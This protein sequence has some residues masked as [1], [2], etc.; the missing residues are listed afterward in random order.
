V[1][2]E[3]APAK[4]NLL[5]H[6]GPR[7]ADGLHELSSLFASLD[8]AD[9]LTIEEASADEVVCHGV[10]GPNLA[11]SAI[12]AFRASAAPALPPLR[13][14]IEKRIP[15]AAGLGGG[16]ADAAA[17]LRA[18]NEIAGRP[19]DANA[20]RA[21]G[22]RLGAD[23]P[24]Q[25]EPR[26]ALVTGAG[27]NV[28]PIALPPMTLLLLPDPQAGSDPVPRNP[29]PRAGP[30][31]KGSDPF[32]RFAGLSTAAVYREADRIGVVRDAL[33]AGLAREVAGW[34]LAELASALENDLEAAAISLRPDLAAR[35][36]AMRRVG[37]LA[38]RVTGSGPTVFGV[39]APGEAPD[40]SG[41][42]RAE[43]AA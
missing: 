31:L 3:R 32:G 11:L 6:V 41:A 8:L 25:I 1:I 4:V 12:E 29:A 14:T 30:N 18:A 10:A 27:E 5:L 24:S 28:D 35:I 36:H 7:R 43:V 17:V 15:V 19:L 34:P 26:H 13:V 39:F 23:V 20:L 42:I 2:R 9:E 22:A 37:A 40:M 16:S 21:L 38:A 33:D